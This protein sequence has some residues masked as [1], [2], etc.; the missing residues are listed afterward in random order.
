MAGL[1]SLPYSSNLKVTSNELFLR[2]TVNRNLEKFLTND[3]YLLEKINSYGLSGIFSIEPYKKD[4]IYGIGSV[5]VYIEEKNGKIEN[6]YL[7]ECIEENNSKEPQ[8]SI[9][10]GFVA[11]FS[12]SGWKNL[13]SFFSIYNSSNEDINLSSFLDYSIS[14]NFYLSHE[15][16]LSLHK[17]G[18]I[19]ENTVAEKLLK[20]DFSNV[21][22]FHDS[23]FWNYETKQVSSHNFAGWY[24]KWGNGVLEYDLT[25][26]LGDN[27]EVKKTISPDG[28][29]RT[30]NC[31]KVNSFIPLSTEECDNSD[32]FLDEDSRSIF[33]KNGSSKEYS[34]GN[35]V[36]TNVV[37][38][39]NEY[40]G[41]IEFPIPFVDDEY[42]VFSSGR[43]KNRNGQAQSPCALAFANR[44]KKS[45][46]AIM[47]IPNYNGA[48]IESVLLSKNVF[49]CQIIG[50]WK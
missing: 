46:T 36:Q 47:A 29:I 44:T 2:E 34:I 40:H 4:Y 45:I 26:C 49:Q 39:T 14:S 28:S 33:N 48:S 12:K 19:D 13:N 42:M 1:I 9:I 22:D 10:D 27:I 37:D 31:I 17:F 21:D 3:L 50:R 41:T 25:F 35:V 24:K 6:I 32:Y 16:D 8:Y 23:V 11:D 5:V 18:A 20:K 15:S 43:M 30:T 7:L 38:Q